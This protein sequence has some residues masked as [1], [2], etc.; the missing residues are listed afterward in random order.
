[1]DFAYDYK[2]ITLEE[3]ETYNYYEFICD[4]DSKLVKVKRREVNE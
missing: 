4:A 1:M 2:N 3:I